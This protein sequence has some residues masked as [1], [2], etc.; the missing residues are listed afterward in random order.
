MSHG[1]GAV[2]CVP[3]HHDGVVEA[4]GSTSRTQGRLCRAKGCRAPAPD[5]TSADRVPMRAPPLS[6][7]SWLFGKQWDQ[8]RRLQVRGRRG[9]Q[10]RHL[11][12]CHQ[13]RAVRGGALQDLL[14]AGAVHSAAVH[15]SLALTR[16]VCCASA[17]GAAQNTN[18][19]GAGGRAQ[20]GRV[21]PGY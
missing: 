18:G 8:P 7:A 9:G 16:S 15:W 19:A 6:L 4:K 2:Q 10:G 11:Q 12:L 17:R 21:L 3:Q 13:T 1:A 5:P 14:D 20:R